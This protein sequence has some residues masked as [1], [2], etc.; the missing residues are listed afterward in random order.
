MIPVFSFEKL[1]ALWFTFRGPEIFSANGLNVLTV[2]STNPFIYTGL[3]VFG[4]KTEN[5]KGV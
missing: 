1:R 5:G 4:K 3:K 2:I